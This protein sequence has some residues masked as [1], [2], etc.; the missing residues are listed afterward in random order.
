MR[1]HKDRK[2]L[3]GSSI[4]LSHGMTSVLF[5]L[6][7]CSSFRY[8]EL[9]NALFCTRQIQSIIAQLHIQ[10]KRAVIVMS[11]KG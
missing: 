8:E 11:T 3:L 1:G 4:W 7:F 2:E 5:R 9:E 10:K 6:S